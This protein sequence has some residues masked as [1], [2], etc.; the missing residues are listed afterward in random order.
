MVFVAVDFRP[1][2]KLRDE[3][4]RHPVERGPGPGDG[5]LGVRGRHEH[6]H[7]GLRRLE[8]LQGLRGRRQM[9]GDDLAGGAGA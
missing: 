1:V 3:F 6:R 7:E 4:S 2:P 5:Q 8:V 9:A